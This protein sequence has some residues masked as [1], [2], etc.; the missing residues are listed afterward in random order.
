MKK[1]ITLLLLFPLFISCSK[2]DDKID[3]TFIDQNLIGV[4]WDYKGNGFQSYSPYICI[5]DNTQ[6]IDYIVR[7]EI[8][9]TIVKLINGTLDYKTTTYGNIIMNGKTYTYKIKN[10][11]EL[12]IKD[13]NPENT[14]I[15]TKIKKEKEYRIIE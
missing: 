2:E 14:A 10:G 11:N 4:Q 5:F 12:I 15:F 3:N 7:S 6:K 9:K 1:L 13:G 8:D